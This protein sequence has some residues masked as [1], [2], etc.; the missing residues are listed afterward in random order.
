MQDMFLK[1]ILNEDLLFTKLG[2][3]YHYNSIP[4]NNGAD[5]T[6]HWM[7]K[8]YKKLYGEFKND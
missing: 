4:D 1:E 8:T 5:L 2:W 3:V 6:F 7:E